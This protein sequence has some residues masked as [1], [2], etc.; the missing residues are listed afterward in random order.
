MVACYPGNGTRYVR[1][2]DNPHGDG[3]LLTVILYLN[4]D[5]DAARFGGA[6]RVYPL[7]VG[8]VAQVRESDRIA[9]HL[10]T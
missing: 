4:R 10:I 5:W 3:R 9:S 2:I 1:H 7:G 8:R 6:L